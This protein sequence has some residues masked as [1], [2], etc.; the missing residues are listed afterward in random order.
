MEIILMKEVLGLGDPGEVV[1]VAKGYGRNYLIPQ[2]MAVMATK[3][4]MNRIEAERKTLEAAQAAEAERI[5]AD[6]ENIAGLSLTVQARAGE[7]GKLYGSV[8][9]MDVA[10]ALEEI[11]HDIDRRRILMD[12]PIKDLGEH[13]VKI[14]LHPQVVVEINLTVEAQEDKE[15][16]AAAAAVAPAAPAAPA[17]AAPA[18]PQPEPEPQAEAE[19][20]AEAPAEE[21][22]AP[23][24]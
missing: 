16:A 12:Q 9:N 10:K 2:G 24:E 4:N 1:N 13:V 17:A 5:R 19:T 18:E 7:G 22:T 14:K 3:S 15:A 11:G 20:E 21:E 6:A 8:T 23:Q